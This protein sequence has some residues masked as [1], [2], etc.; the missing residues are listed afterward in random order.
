MSPYAESRS[1][2]CWQL[3]VEEE[4]RAPS[5]G[6]HVNFEGRTGAASRICCRVVMGVRIGVSIN[7]LNMARGS[8]FVDNARWKQKTNN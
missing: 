4:G 3:S 6:T 5:S 8:H 1:S 7:I 2:L